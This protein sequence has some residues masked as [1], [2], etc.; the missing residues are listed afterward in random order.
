MNIKNI[1]LNDNGVSITFNTKEKDSEQEWKV[2]KKD[3]L[4]F[5]KLFNEAIGEHN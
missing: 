1:E 4:K 2:D 3:I 5:Y